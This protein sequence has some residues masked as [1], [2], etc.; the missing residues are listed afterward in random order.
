MHHRYYLQLMCADSDQWFRE[1]WEATF[2]CGSTGAISCDRWNSLN[3]TTNV[4]WWWGMNSR[5][6][7]G[8]HVYAHAIHRAIADHCPQAFIKSPQQSSIIKQCLNGELVL[9]YLKVCQA[10]SNKSSPRAQATVTG[11]IFNVTI[12]GETV[13]NVRHR[14][15]S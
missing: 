4:D 7:D 6:Y 1:F 13:C 11:A 9:A 2:K 8:V 15:N 3:E 12:S 10:T 5:V 14:N